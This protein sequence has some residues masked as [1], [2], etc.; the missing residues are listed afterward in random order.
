MTALIVGVSAPLTLSRQ[1]A[2][3]EFDDQIAVLRNQMG[4]FEAQA[5]ELNK[6][7]NSLQ[8][9]LDQITA[10]KNAIMA[11]IDLSQKQ[12][13]QLQSQIDTTK[14]NIA[15]NRSALG[16]IIADMYVAS[17]ISPLEMLASSSNVGEFIDKQE[18]RSSIQDNLTKTIDK[19]DALKKKLEKSQK[20]VRKVLDQQKAQKAQLAA[21]E[22]ERAELV[23]QTR[24][25]E[26]AYKQLASDTQA[27]MASASAQQ[28]AYYEAL[29]AQSASSSAGGADSGVVGSFSYANWSGNQGCGS[30]GYQ[31]CGEQDTYADPW[32]LYNRECVSYAAWRIERLGHKVNHFGGRGNAH[33]WPSSA[34]ATRV[35]DPK[36]GDA[37]VLPIVAGFAPVGHLMVV[38]SVSA[39]WVHVSQY[40]FYGTGEYSTMDIKKTG[41][42][43]LRFP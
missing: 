21:K 25:D 26:A 4:E 41:V 37:V 24:G 38:E 29:R 16:L 8:A 2:A 31:Y 5:N 12:Y 23:A 40:N 42:I 15:S 30:D 14:K 9:E 1:A 18:F 7:A 22:S 19:I 17:S 39:D 36:P 33:E 20:D 10:Q 13:D 35:D 3:D 43:F 32:G 27:Q 6:R 28:R 34:N 11:Q